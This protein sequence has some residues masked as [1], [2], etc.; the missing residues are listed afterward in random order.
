MTLEAVP[1]PF[2]PFLDRVVD[3]LATEALPVGVPQSLPA[4]VGL[5]RG[6]LRIRSR[7][8]GRL[9]GRVGLA[10]GCGVI[11][12]NDLLP[13]PAAVP[14]GVLAAVLNRPCGVPPM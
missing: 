9:R 4:R 12:G 7:R 5:G 14:A 10:A 3:L 1:Q 2:A 11:G 6:D 13:S 8:V